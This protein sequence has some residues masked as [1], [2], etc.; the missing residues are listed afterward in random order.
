MRHPDHLHALIA[1][2][3]VDTC[4]RDLI[5]MSSFPNSPRLI[6]VGIVRVNADSGALLRV[7]TLPFEPSCE[8]V[9]GM[10]R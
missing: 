1:Y 5:P 8:E 7:I 2:P 10:V 4:G 9:R 6:K 3:G